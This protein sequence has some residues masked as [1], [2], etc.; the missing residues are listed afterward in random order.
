MMPLLR[1][2]HA[3]VDSVE[4]VRRGDA[5][6]FEAI[7]RAYYEPLCRFARMYGIEREAAEDLVQ[8]VFFRIWEE[9]AGWEVHGTLAAYLYGATRNRVLDYVRHR[10]VHRAWEARAARG[11]ARALRGVRSRAEPADE[12]LALDE[13]DVATRHAIAQL[14]ERCRQT[15]VLSRG[16]GLAY[17]E[18]AVVMHVSVKTVKIQMGRALKSL[19]ASL[20]PFIGVDPPHR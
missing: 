16:H 8:D 7:F 18:I 17:A 19:R 5:T 6:A 11:S 10:L 4:L 12:R 14:P 2:E 13:L 15:F 9:R 1:S 3:H 20:A